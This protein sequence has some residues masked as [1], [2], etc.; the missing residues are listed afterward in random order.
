MHWMPITENP[1]GVVE[2]CIGIY[3]FWFFVRW[4]RFLWW[5][6]RRWSWWWWWFR[7]RSWRW[8]PVI[9]IIAGKKTSLVGIFFGSYFL[10]GLSFGNW[11]WFI[12]RSQSFL[13]LPWSQ[14]PKILA[15]RNFARVCHSHQFWKLTANQNKPV[16]LPWQS[17]RVALLRL[18]STQ[19]QLYKV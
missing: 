12:R 10:G 14:S 18:L 13:A 11:C 6:I 19:M 4:P 17:F 5:R 15:T 2:G 3:I 9:F 7:W 1:Q 8:I 16:K